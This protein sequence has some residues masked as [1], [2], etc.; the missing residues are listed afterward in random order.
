MANLVDLGCRD[1]EGNLRIVVETPKGSLAKL[2]YNPLWG[3]FELQRF[4]SSGGYPYDWGFVPSTLA[5]DGDPLDAMVIHEGQ[6]W[7]GVVIPCVALALL[8]LNE[9]K[10]GE[11][12]GRQN[13]RLMVAPAPSLLRRTSIELGPQV[14]AQLEQFF[15]A[16]G[17]LANK[18][19]SL[20]GWG[21]ES[22]VAEAVA[23][24]SQAFDAKARPA[25][26]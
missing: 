18:R 7:P 1:D 23:R 12:H 4:I 22:E 26:P 21:N 17:E 20:N 14:R 11:T 8:R 9:V 19:V 25:A 3:T 13:D 2:K 24:A 10:A 15:V 6:T 16:T 5:Q